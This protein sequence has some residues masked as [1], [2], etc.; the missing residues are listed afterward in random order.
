M[1]LA[2]NGDE[3]ILSKAVTVNLSVGL[4][5]D[6]DGEPEPFKALTVDLFLFFTSRR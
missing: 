6:S 3:P 5:C 4:R 2:E 1:D